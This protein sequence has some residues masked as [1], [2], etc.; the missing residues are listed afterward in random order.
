[1]EEA[2]ILLLIKNMSNYKIELEK[3]LNLDKDVKIAIIT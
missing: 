3:E 2:T 1:V